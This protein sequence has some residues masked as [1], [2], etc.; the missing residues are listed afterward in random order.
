MTTATLRTTPTLFDLGDHTLGYHPKRTETRLSLVTK[1]NHGVKNSLA[2]TRSLNKV[3][4][5]V[6]S[7]KMQEKSSDK[8]E[9]SSGQ[10][11]I[12]LA[13]A[14]RDSLVRLSGP[15]KWSDTRESWLARGARRA[16]I[17]VRQAK[18]LF[19]METQNPCGALV[20]QVQQAVA[21]MDAAEATAREY[22]ALGD[23]SALYKE[24]IAKRD[25]LDTLIARARNTSWSGDLAA[26]DR[27]DTALAGEQSP[28]P[29]GGSDRTLDSLG[30]KI[31]ER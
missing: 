10:P 1:I 12:S 30:E 19:Y 9:K 18:T 26:L 28:G 7:S 11:E 6:R 15:R 22:A 27:L 16:G 29:A 23:T 2:P 13:T 20:Y 31:D 21:A 3:T 4:V 14:M 25:E 8:P 24:L 17:T 5:G